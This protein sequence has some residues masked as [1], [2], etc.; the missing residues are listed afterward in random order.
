MISKK[1]CK[2]CNKEIHPKRVALGY[3]D[4]CV[5]HSTAQKFTGHLVV[6]GKTDYSI[7]IIKDPEVGKKL[8]QLYQASIG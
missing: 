4:T 7:Q 8:K 6:D 1:Y 5:D 2:V 3:P